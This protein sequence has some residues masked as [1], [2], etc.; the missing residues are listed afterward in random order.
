LKLYIIYHL[1]SFGFPV[2]RLSEVVNLKI[3]HHYKVRVKYF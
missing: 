2:K 3:Y 1:E